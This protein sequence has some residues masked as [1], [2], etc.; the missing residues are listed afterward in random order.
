MLGNDP[1]LKFQKV[2]DGEVTEECVEMKL[3]EFQWPKGGLGLCP[4]CGCDVQGQGKEWKCQNE[5]CGLELKGP[6]F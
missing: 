1:I 2:T 3:K 6:I 5:D 4:V